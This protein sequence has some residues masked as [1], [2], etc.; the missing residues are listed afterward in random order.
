MVNEFVESM[1]KPLI[2]CVQQIGLKKYHVYQ[3]F[4]MY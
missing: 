1:V 2:L 4:Q 3:V